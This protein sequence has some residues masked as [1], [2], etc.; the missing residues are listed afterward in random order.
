MKT[1][2]LHGT[3]ANQSSNT[4]ING[5]ATENKIST[6]TP[7]KKASKD[8]ITKSYVNQSDERN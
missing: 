1:V 7:N 3:Q 4:S 6:Y 2:G 5:I 8:K